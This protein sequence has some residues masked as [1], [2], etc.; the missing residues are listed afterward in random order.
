MVEVNSGLL[1]SIKRLFSTLVSVASTRLQLLANELEE[2]RLHWE[3]MLLYF[4]AALFC[5]G[6]AL[7]LLTVFV[8]AMFWD[9]HRLAV[10]GGAGGLFLVTGILLLSVLLKIK[11]RKSTLFSVSLAELAKDRAQLG[12]DDETQ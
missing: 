8:V 10:L 12:G 1:V 11:Q 3:R 9:T 4:L 6:M 7:M 5:F 2:E